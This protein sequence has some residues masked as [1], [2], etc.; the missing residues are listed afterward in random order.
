M[1]ITLA[2]IAAPVALAL[3]PAIAAASPVADN[4]FSAEVSTDDIDLTTEDG[5]SRLDDRIRSR[6]RQ[7]C[8]TGGRDSASLRLE[9]QCRDTALA[10]AETQVRFAV[11]AANADRRRLAG[12]TSSTAEGAATPGA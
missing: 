4:A 3:T 11:A 10:A 2:L 1:R 5:V 8:A 9:R 7:E 6:I 12:N